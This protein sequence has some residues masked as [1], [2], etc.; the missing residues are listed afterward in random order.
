MKPT[1]V[2][3]STYIDIDLKNNNK[4]PKPEVR[5]HVRISKYNS[6]FAKGYTS[7]WLEKVFV[8]KEVKSNVPWTYVINDLNS[9]KIV[10]KFHEKELQKPNQTKFSVEKV[11]RKER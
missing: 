11:M 8:I 4:D 6:I 2:K 5:D 7:I 3:T 9:E 1:D 10:G